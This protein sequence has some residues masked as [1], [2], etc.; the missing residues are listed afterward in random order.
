MNDFCNVHVS[1]ILA[2]NDITSFF[3]L[4]EV[5]NNLLE[6]SY[7]VERISNMVIALCKW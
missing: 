7:L 5:S 6:T 2:G 3:L 1:F 4:L